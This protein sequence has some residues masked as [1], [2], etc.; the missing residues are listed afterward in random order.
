MGAH[1]PKESKQSNKAPS[2][3]KAGVSFHKRLA[4]GALGMLQRQR[5]RLL[6]RSRA[7][8]IEKNAP[9]STISE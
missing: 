3:V 8:A 7:F 4:V 1:V 9:F 5:I 2:V 6:L